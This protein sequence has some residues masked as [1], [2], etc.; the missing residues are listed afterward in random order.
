[1]SSTGKITTAIV[2]GIIVLGGVWFWST[3]TTQ[4]QTGVVAHN[5]PS[6][7]TTNP[8]P[9][10]VNQNLA[11]VDAQMSA[12]ASDSASIDQGLNDQPVSQDQL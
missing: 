9:G 6:Q 2:V 12:L 3:G 1:M 5:A 4:P 7:G 10:D 8:P 11:Q